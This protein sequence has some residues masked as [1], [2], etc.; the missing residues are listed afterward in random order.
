MMCSSI[1][2]ITLLALHP[3]SFSR[4]QVTVEG[5]QVRHTL[6]FQALTL[7][8][9]L[10]VDTS[11]DLLLDA[12]EL[13]PAREVIDGYLREHY[14]LYPD[15]GRGAPLEGELLRLELFLEGDPSLPTSTWVEAEFTYS[16]SAPLEALVLEERLFEISNP[17]H[18]EFVSV[19]WGGE[20]PRDHVFYPEEE[21]WTCTPTGV[22][23][24]GRLRTFFELGVSHILGGYD[25]LLFLF[26]LL[27]AV[28]GLRSLAWVVTAFT[29]AH[30]V[31][32]ALAALEIF[33]LPGRFVELAIALSIVYVAA[34]NLMR[35]DKRSLWLEA[36]FFGLLHGLGFAGF[37]G[38]ALSGEE[39]LGLPLLGFNLGVEAGQLLVVLPL[40]AVFALLARR[41]GQVDASEDAPPPL[42]PATVGRLVSAVIVLVGL[43]WFAERAGFVG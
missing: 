5:M 22:V 17:Q 18:V 30:S 1:A 37:L 25:H 13:T 14:R 24:P 4:S 39:G 38:D 6:R 19:A 40:A 8:E 42:V 2:L 7:I 28:R 26:A 12:N 41:R 11:G 16:H 43:Y 34:E 31:T 20:L 10:P 9:T 29:L 33:T 32:L 36:F 35:I 23:P 15:E 27:V 21:R 3:G